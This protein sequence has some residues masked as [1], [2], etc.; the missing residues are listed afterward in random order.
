MPTLN[1]EVL[2]NIDDGYHTST[3]MTDNAF[4]AVG[5]LAGVTHHLWAR[6]GNISGL[7]GATIAS[8]DLGYNAVLVLGAPTTC[9]FAEDIAAPMR[10]ATW[11]DYQS[12]PLTTAFVDESYAAPTGP[13]TVDIATVVQELVDSYNPSGIHVLHKDNGSPAGNIAV[14]DAVNGG[15]SPTLDIDYVP[16]AVPPT[17]LNLV[18]TAALDDGYSADEDFKT[19]DA[20]L[21]V[22]DEFFT[23]WD[24]WLRFTE[25]IS[26]LGGATIDSAILQ[27]WVDGFD[28]NPIADVFAEDAESPLAPTSRADHVAKPRTTAGVRWDHFLDVPVVAPPYRTKDIASVIQELVDSYDPTAIQ[29]LHD[30]RAGGNI[31]YQAF[32]ASVGFIP[33]AHPARLVINYTP[34]PGAII[35]ARGRDDTQI[36][37]RGRDDT[38]IGLRGRDD[39][40]IGL[41]GRDDAIIGLRGRDDTTIHL[42]G[43]R[44]DG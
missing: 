37:L 13:K 42:K 16:A 24:A 20:T 1:L 19:G 10:A 8:A 28:P 5:D 44:D 40:T 35:Y 27:I 14:F 2:A 36:G 11:D 6:F 4:L 3:T 31:I 41:R 29:I 39:A 18:V 34:A 25:G 33:P 22:G 38:Q 30:G 15:N 23:L 43:E 17:T 9:I 26:G 32:D 21:I 12:R 7:G